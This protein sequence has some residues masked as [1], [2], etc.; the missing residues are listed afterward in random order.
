M[1]PAPP[2]LF[3]SHG[4]PTMALDAGPAASFLRDLGR[5]WPRPAAILAVSA[6]WETESPAVSAAPAP[7]TIHDF[8]GFPPALYALRHAAPGAPA[9]AHRVAGL[10]DAAGMEATV[11]P[12]RGLDHGAWIPALLAWPAA[13][14]PI[15]QL[16]V[17]PARDAAH[18]VAVGRALASLRAEGVLVLA[19]G[20]ATHNLRL[21]RRTARATPD[22]WAQ[23]FDDWLAARI[24]AG[25]TAAL[26]TW[27]ADAPHA[28]TAHPRSEH[29]LP[30]FVALGAGGEGARGK[31]LHRGFE[32]GN[33]SM[34][35]FAFG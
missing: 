24:E 12:A 21:L 18:H 3:V 30:L 8:Y 25:D 9:L 23:A 20:G 13:D 26:L 6:H 29:L 19:S 4:A 17:Q 14:V 22:P 28:V 33:L 11:D 15:L 5:R 16:S 32:L 35:A 7:E 10:L 27:R 2:A 34:A 31:A 1:I